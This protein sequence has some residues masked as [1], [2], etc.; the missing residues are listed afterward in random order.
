MRRAL[1]FATAACL[2]LPGIAVGARV[3][4]ARVKPDHFTVHVTTTSGGPV[5]FRAYATTGAELAVQNAAALIP[6]GLPAAVGGARTVVSPFG[7]SGTTPAVFGA[8]LLA[9]EIVFEAVDRS[10]TLRVDVRPPIDSRRKR[11]VGEGHRVVVRRAG[12]SVIVRTR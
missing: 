6:G 9:G 10:A 8:N 11:V 12:D 4:M 7:G 5:A 3:S 2:T 1:A